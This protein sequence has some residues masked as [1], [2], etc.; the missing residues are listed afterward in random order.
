LSEVESTVD[1][2]GIIANGQLGYQGELPENNAALEKLF[3]DVVK[4]KRNVEDFDHD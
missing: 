1:S 4:E 3:M 2:I